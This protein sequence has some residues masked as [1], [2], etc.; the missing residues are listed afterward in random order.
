VE[1]GN[2]RGIGRLLAHPDPDETVAF[3]RRIVFGLEIMRDWQAAG[4]V[5]ALPVA[6]EADA[7][8]TALK[9]VA[10]DLAG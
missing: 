8:V 5:G 1:V 4:D 10:A 9:R 7:V 3:E 2:E 6:I